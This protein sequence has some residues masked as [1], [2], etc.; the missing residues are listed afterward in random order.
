MTGLRREEVAERAF[1]S[2]EY[3]TRIEQGRMPPSSEVLDQLITALELDDDQARYARQLLLGS[4]LRTLPASVGPSVADPIRRLLVR[5]GDLPAMVI[6]PQTSI[7]AWNAAAARLFVDF[8]AIPVERRTYVDLLFDNPTFQS[9]FRDLDAMKD[10]VVGIVRSTA[11]SFAADA[12]LP[13][14]ADR[15]PEFRERWD[16]YTVTQPREQLQIPFRDPDHGDVT[17]DQVVLMFDDPSQRL[18][19]F[20]RSSDADAEFTR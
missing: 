19:L 14:L 8:A 11:N 3:Y 16:R 9:R 20:M 18:L 5:F 4:G 10:V 2:C 15:N 7:L 17:V 1:I 13:E 6:G 12:H